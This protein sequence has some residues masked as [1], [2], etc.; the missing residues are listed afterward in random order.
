MR[1]DVDN[2]AART[3]TDEPAYRRRRPDDRQ[4]EVETDELGDPAP[5]RG[6]HRRIPENR[7]VVDPAREGRACLRLVGR[8]FGHDLVRG[9]TDD[10]DEAISNRVRVD[11]CQRL[12]V[13]IDDDNDAG[14]PHVVCLDQPVDH[15]APD[16]SAAAGDNIR[17]AHHHDDAG[18]YGRRGTGP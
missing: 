9:I 12:V 1:R 2:R 13:E 16:P 3:H 10:A 7:G 15:S 5:A 14:R 6:R 17:P 18:R 8:M 4:V 11:P